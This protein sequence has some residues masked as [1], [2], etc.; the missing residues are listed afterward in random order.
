MT[1]GRA[2]HLAFL[3][4]TGAGSGAQRVMVTLAKEIA[5]RGR[6]V[7]LVVGRAEGPFV[8]GL[9]DDVRL[10]P[11]ERSG[12][13]AGRWSTWRADPSGLG[14]LARPFLLPLSTSD[15]VYRLPALTRYLCENRPDV[16]MSAKVHTNLIALL[17]RRAA[18][19]R[20]RLV[21]SERGDYGD[22]IA[23]SRRWRWRHI[24][25]LMRRLYA[26]ADAIVS[27]S[28]DLAK[29]LPGYTGLD[30]TRIQVLH[31]PVVSVSLHH[32]AQET[33]DHAWFAPGEPPVIMA[34]G[35]LETRKGFQDLITAF[36]KL[37]K[38]QP[39]EQ[40]P[41]RLVIF[42]EG[43]LRIA[44]ERQIES[45]GLSDHV[46]LPGWQPNLFAYMARA[47]LFVLPSHYEG[48]PGV[49]IQALACGCPVVATDCPTGPREILADGRYGALTPVG[50]VNALADAI[51]ET[52]LA[53]HSKAFL[54]ARG[55]DFSVER[56]IE[57]YLS[58]FDG[59]LDQGAT[60]ATEQE[61]SSAVVARAEAVG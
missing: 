12:M 50:D 18:G 24:A 51:N 54:Q 23:N 34:A 37:S 55:A 32:Q 36:A 58:L 44:L 11:L 45:L 41:R 2:E 28:E 27:V 3:I 19:V 22:K 8:E 53:P 14:A 25:P 4:P 30:P 57:R 35:R 48:L 31:N 29:R 7:D 46:D 1:S 5:A 47:A 49:L 52:L 16:L 60:L 10:V 33:I 59:L 9:S 17:A 56:A 6:R 42:G 38:D 15:M 21:V 20:T 43:K 39:T 26:H 13:I 40:L 61:L